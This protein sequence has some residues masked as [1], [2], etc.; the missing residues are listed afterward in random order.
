MV[1]KYYLFRQSEVQKYQEE[2]WFE[3]ESVAVTNENL[4][5]AYGQGVVLI[6][7]ERVK[8]YNA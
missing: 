7:I 3:E 5:A 4:L 8:E 2:D 1:E 6:P